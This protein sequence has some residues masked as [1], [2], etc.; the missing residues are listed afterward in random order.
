MRDERT[1]L[2]RKGD[3]GDNGTTTPNALS[4]QTE[5]EEAAGPGPSTPSDTSS[6]GIKAIIMV[7]IL[8][9]IRPAFLNVFSVIPAQSAN[10]VVMIGVFVANAD[11]N[12]LITVYGQI[13]SEFNHFSNAGWLLLMY[14]LA[15]CATQTLV[16]ALDSTVEA[17]SLNACC[18]QYG[19]L[20]DIYGRK[21]SVLA[22]YVLFLVGLGLWYVFLVLSKQ[23]PSSLKCVSYDCL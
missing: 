14:P 11:G 9:T 3:D 22:A 7:L 19:K 8:G 12:F 5:Q 20:S 1:P 16:R 21:S 23:S 15:T 13:A 2:I 10:A 18:I 17:I 6:T 4:P